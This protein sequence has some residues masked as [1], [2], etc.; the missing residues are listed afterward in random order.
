MKFILDKK[1]IIRGWKNSLYVLINLESGESRHISPLEFQAISFCDGNTDIDDIFILEPHKVIIRNFLKDDIIH[2]SSDEKINKN[3]KYFS[4]DCSY[5]K[6]IHWSITR[7][8]NCNC[9]HCYLSSPDKKYRD[10]PLDKCFEIIRQIAEC[11]IQKISLTGGE[12]LIRPDF[13]QIVDFILENKIKLSRIYTNGMAINESLIYNLKLRNIKPEFSI[14][15]DG[16]GFHDW[17]RG[18]KGAEI[19]AVNAFKILNKN[20][21]STFSEMCLYKDNAHT[22]FDTVNFLTNLGVSGLKINVV[23]NTGSWMN[24]KKNHEIS[25]KKAYDAFLRYI[26]EFFGLGSPMNLQMAGVFACFKGSRNFF[27]PAVKCTD[28]YKASVCEH[29]KEVL[30]LSSEGEVLPCVS[31][32][33]AKTNIKKTFITKSNTLK[34]ILN[35]SY[36]LSIINLKIKEL[37]KKNKTCANCKYCSL[38]GGGCRANAVLSGGNYFGIDL[39]MCEFFKG[40]YFEKIKEIAKI[41]SATVA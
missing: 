2:I 40:G 28:D 11:G 17:L 14:S 25:T 31:I 4:Y 15:F 6:Q 30:Y 39:Q 22:I 35:K 36:Y 41:G 26:P 9:R 21:F 13:W 12:A 19:S 34:N 29:A 16:I 27:V 3:Q 1:Y 8:C 33:L 5:I 18:I 10:M 32:D 7:N 38:C 24:N 23:S 37:L 20:G